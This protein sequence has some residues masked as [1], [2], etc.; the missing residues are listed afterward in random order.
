MQ[1]WINKSF[2]GEK[3]EQPTRQ[4]DSK[5][6]PLEDAHDRRDLL[7]CNSHNLETNPSA[8][9]SNFTQGS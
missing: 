3:T 4:N 2:L 9:T 1:S 6:T 8:L 5:S 7:F